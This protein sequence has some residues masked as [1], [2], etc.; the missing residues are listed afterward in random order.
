MVRRVFHFSLTVLLMTSLVLCP[1]SCM[2]SPRVI[3]QRNEKK[4][5]ASS[6]KCPCC[7]SDSQSEQPQRR[8]GK[9]YPTPGQRCACICICTG[10]ITESSG[11]LG[12][13]DVGWRFDL[14]AALPLVERNPPVLAVFWPLSPGPPLAKPLSGR[15]IRTLLESLL[16]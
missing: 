13:Q 15:E 8:S 12:S 9:S 6:R 11:Q 14:P 16:L 7:R 10:A 1:Y 4:P 2:G 5:A 3:G